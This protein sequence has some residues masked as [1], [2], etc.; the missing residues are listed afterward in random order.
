MYSIDLNDIW[1]NDNSI[2]TRIKY[3]PS[4]FIYKDG[5]VINYLDSS[6]DDDYEYYKS[7]E[8]LSEWFDKNIDISL[9]EKCSKCKVN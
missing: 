5:V 8:K 9:F 1:G 7:V 3:A 4:M 2:T 6:K